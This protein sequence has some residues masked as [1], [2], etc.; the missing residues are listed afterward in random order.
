VI[1]GLISLISPALLWQPDSASHPTASQF[2]VMNY[3]TRVW[4]AGLAIGTS[5][6]IAQCGGCWESVM[7]NLYAIY[8]HKLRLMEA[9][10]TSG[11][12]ITKSPYLWKRSFWGFF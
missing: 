10:I 9:L 3:A 12:V 5:S 11:P 1:R 2:V 4:N 7:C 8:T 6:E